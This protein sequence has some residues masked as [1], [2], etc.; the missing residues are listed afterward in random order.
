MFDFEN[1][2]VY[3]KAKRINK[4]VAYY[5]A[6]NSIDRVTHDQLRRAAFSVMLNIA[7]GSGRYTRR[8]K[9]N[10]FVIARGSVFECVAIFDY[11][12]ESGL[13]SS[14]VFQSYYQR[15]EE[16]SKMLFSLIK[17]LE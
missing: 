16:L 10:F 4:S 7:E 9:R 14:E 12:M 8:D 15:L 13:I 11:V 17:G 2:E 3:K 5:L 6:N 1:L